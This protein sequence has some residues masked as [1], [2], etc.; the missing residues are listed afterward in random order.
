MIL[1]GSH[2]YGTPTEESDLDFFVVA[3][4]PEAEVRQVAKN[5]RKSVRRFALENGVAVDVVVDSPDRI[6]YRIETV[7]DSFYREVFTLGKVVY[8]Q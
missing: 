8:A 4:V 3:D 2:A 7:K 5:A 1:F 6:A